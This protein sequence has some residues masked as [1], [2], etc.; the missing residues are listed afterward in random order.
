MAK[1]KLINMEGKPIHF[2]GTSF[3]KVDKLTGYMQGGDVDNDDGT[4][5]S[6]AYYPNPFFMD[7]DMTLH[8]HDRP[9]L[10]TM[11]RSHFISPNSN[12]S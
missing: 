1:E 7:E 12:N 3:F 2:K 4:G 6:S 9:F 10:L 11:G 8:K 5:G